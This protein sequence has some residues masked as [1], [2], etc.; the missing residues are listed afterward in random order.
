[1]SAAVLP[2]PYESGQRLRSPR[3]N[4]S[5]AT[6]VG[7]KTHIFA[8]VALAAAA[9]FGL[10]AC[11]DDSSGS[12]GTSAADEGPKHQKF[13][14]CMEEHGMDVPDPGEVKE[15]EL[16]VQAPGESSAEQEAARVACAKYAPVQDAPE[17]VTKD[18]QDRALKK[19][20]CLRK[21]GIAAEDPKPGTV[22]ITIKEGS[23]SSQEKL[24]DAFALCNK[25]FGG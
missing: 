22:D 24:V 1:M 2:F 5:T 23:D 13:Q 25:K 12:G 9:T 8:A 21:E 6:L 19:A 15:G 20:E 3:G 4:L 10:T 18:D 14:K 7:M 16:D 17:D 11:G